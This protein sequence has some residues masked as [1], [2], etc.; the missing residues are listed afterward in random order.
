MPSQPSRV[1]SVA[2]TLVG[3]I[4]IFGL[5]PLT[6]VWPSGWSWLP[7][8]PAYLQMILGIYVTLGV[9]LVLAAR[10]PAIEGSGPAA[11]GAVAATAPPACRSLSSG[12]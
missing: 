1:L 11:P 7:D 12:R 3:L 2:L 6:V 9:F 4:F 10:D 8:Q 5:Y